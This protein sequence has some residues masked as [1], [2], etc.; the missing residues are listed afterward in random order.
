[1][2]ILPNFTEGTSGT[3]LTAYFVLPMTN[4]DIIDSLELTAKLMELHEADS[5]KI[6]AY[7]SAAFN[8]DKITVPLAGMS[9]AELARLQGVGKSV[10]GKITEIQETGKLRDLEEL[11]DK[12]PPGILDM[13]KVKG[14]GAK[15]IAVIW[16]DL[17]IE[18]L[19]DLELACQ[20]GQIAKLKGFG[21]STQQKIL[22]SLVFLKS[23]AGKLRMNVADALAQAVRDELQKHFD[24][25]EIAG[26]IRR[27]AE[28]VE[29]VR[30]LV[31][32][33]KP[34]AVQQQLTTLDILT[35]D[36]RQSTPF[37]WRG[38]AM[39]VD[40]RVEIIAVPADRF[41]NELFLE[42]STEAH[43]TQM[44]AD[45][46]TLLQLAQVET[47]A[48]EEEIYEKAGL[49]YI[50]PEMREGRGE[51][52]WAQQHAPADLV[53]WDGLR[54]ILHNHSTYSDGQHTVEQMALFCRELGFEYL[55]MAD[56][57]QSATYAS[58]LRPDQVLRQ[59]E[60]IDRLNERFARE[61]PGRPFKVL[62]GIES[63]ILGDGSLDYPDDTLATFDYV[64]ASVH[65]NLTMT[66]DKA[67]ARLLRAIENPYTTILGHPTGRLLLSRDGYPIDYKTIIDAC[68]ERGVVMEI[69]ASP[70]RLDLDWRWVSYCMEKG[71]LLSINPDAHVREGYFDMHY[72]IA[73]GRKGGLTT[74]MTFNALSLAEIDQFL[75]KRKNR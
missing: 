68:A 17:G 51:W 5:F 31:A 1:M 40:V 41:A 16:R 30:L 52:A 66:E 71:V 3:T 19:R 11:M 33:D 47:V 36:P 32:N 4:S 60:E 73:T 49:P 26:E 39:D 6:K 70:W 13:F 65:S 37:V 64:V 56:H 46:R 18:N 24:R 27:R 59:H 62:K 42:T 48:S 45:G 50:V 35:Q 10:A 8:L 53:T 58:G 43:L 38:K 67:T 34:V 63:D 9:P 29:T 69:N 75:T 57:S 55:G 72:G 20:S 28:T 22:D 74:E 54:G 44:A 23:Q 15:K 14:I 2:K 12:T 61:N 7:T 21:E 25:V